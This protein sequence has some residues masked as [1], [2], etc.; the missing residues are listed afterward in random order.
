MYGAPTYSLIRDIAYDRLENMLETARVPYQLNKAEQILRIEKYGKILFRTLERPERLIGFQVFRAYLDELDTMKTKDAEDVWNKIIARCRQI[1]PDNTS[2][3]NQIFVATTPEG[4]SFVYQRWERDINDENR[5][6]Y[7][8]IKAS[9]YSNKYLPPGYVDDLKVSYPAA[10]V[11]AYI[12][13]E[14]VN[15]KNKTVY[16]NFSRKTHHSDAEI[17][18]GDTLFVGMDFNVLNMSAVV[19]VIRGGKPIAVAEVAKA[20]DTP[21]MIEILK[22]RYMGDGQRHSVIVY[23][24]ASGKNA[25]S[26]DA[27]KSDIKLLREAGFTV[28]ARSK[29][30]NVKDRVN[31]MQAMFL[32]ARGE[33]RYTVNTRNCPQYTSALEHQVYDDNGVP[34]KDPKTNV[35]DMNDAGGYFIHYE[36][37]IVRREFT[38]ETT[39]NF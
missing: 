2:A 18:P 16:S 12:N 10:L 32:N 37:P 33:I 8:L 9:S 26:L 39:N 17:A 38:L 34:E 15:M 27:S 6:R 13:G 21:D 23:P 5:S 14:F 29:N 11:D 1:D 35:D 31:S 36:F 28:K 4:Y 22:Y 25:K 7:K 24:D 20:K 19:H 30:P 3:E